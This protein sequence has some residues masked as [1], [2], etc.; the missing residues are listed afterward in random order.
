MEVEVKLRLPTAEAHQRVADLL[1]AYHQV[2]HLQQNFFFDGENG[3]LSSKKAV[4]RLRFYGADS[5]KCIASLKGKATIANGISTVSE[6]EEEVADA[7]SAR[8]CVA[9][10]RHLLALDST[11]INR[12]TQDFQVQN[13]I[14][15]GSFRNVRNVFH[16]E[17]LVLELDETQ[18][19]FG[20]AYEIECE[21]SDPEHARSVLEDF[22][23]HHGIPFSYSTSSKFAMFRAGKLPDMQA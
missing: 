7:A 19:D 23:N 11:L 12:I 9:E 8:A 18:Y 21:T 10:P 1:A 3:E 13:F 14:C 17:N 20:T 2:T 16:W 22:L 4:M 5:R 6:E 15:L